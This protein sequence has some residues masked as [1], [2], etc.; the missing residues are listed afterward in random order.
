MFNYLARLSSEY[1]YLS[2]FRLFNS[3]MFRS[4]AAMIVSLLFSIFFGKKIINLLYKKGM[5]D[6][7][8]DYGGI[9]VNDKKGTPTMG[10]LIIISALLLSIF[11]WSKLDSPFV[12][13]SS[14]SLIWFGL[15]GFYDDYMK[16]K[17]KNS[18]KGL[19]QIM[20]IILQSIFAIAIAFFFYLE[21]TS[22]FPNDIITELSFPFLKYGST[23]NIGFLYIPFVFFIVISIANAV[24]FADGMDGLSI[25][26]AVT[27]AVV[28]AI[29]AYIIGNIKL[30]E[31]LLFDYIKGNGEIVIMLSGFIGAGL[32]FLW[33]NC[34]PATIFMGDTG[35]MAIGGFLAS[36]VIATKQ[37][38]LFLIA[39]GIFVIEAFS[40]LVQQKIGINYLGRRFFFRAP[41]H[42][43]F[44]HRG[45]PETKIVLRFWIVSVVLALVSIAS[46]KIR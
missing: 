44:Q 33:Y 38:F 9:G 27:T 20:K 28:Y 8:R 29:L 10:G 26:P 22:P 11:L 21:A 13:V 43:S 15:I 30:S 12:I 17:Y 41:L 24:N 42:H 5:R 23:L 31:Y 1:H 16:V 32:G 7:V 34:Y 36:V 4:I 25:V 6:I 3:I 18:D 19:S 40:V 46:I 14:L 2:F 45:I 35:S 39:G 37:E